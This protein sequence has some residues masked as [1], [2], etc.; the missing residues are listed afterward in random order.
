MTERQE[1]AGSAQGEHGLAVGW[2]DVKFQMAEPE[3]L[4]VARAAGFQRGWHVLDAGCGNYGSVT[5]MPDLAA[6]VPDALTTMM[7]RPPF[8][9]PVAVVVFGLTLMVSRTLGFLLFGFAT[10]LG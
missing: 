3:Y 1:S 7:N 9:I 4:A 8:E 2:L 5:L 6:N 10:I